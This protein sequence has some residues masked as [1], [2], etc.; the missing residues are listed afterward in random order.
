MDVNSVG[1]F[2]VSSEFWKFVVVLIPM[3]L[4]TFLVVILLQAVWTVRQREALRKMAADA[5]VKDAAAIAL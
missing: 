2:F 5:V 3:V 1:T 4:L